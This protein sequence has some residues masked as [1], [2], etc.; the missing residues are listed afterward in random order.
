MGTFSDNFSE[1]EKGILRS[2]FS[3]SDSD[4]FAITTPSQVDRGSLMARYSRTDKSMRRVFLDEFLTNPNRGPEFYRRVLLEYGDD[5]VAELGDAQIAIENVSQITVKKIEDSRI[6][7]S[8]LEKSTR[9]VPFNKKIN[10]MYRYLRDEDLMQSRYAD[11]YLETSDLM[12]D[13]YSSLIEP[14]MKYIKEVKPITSEDLFLDKR[15][16]SGFRFSDLK[17]EADIKSVTKAY[18]AAAR[19]KSLDTIRGLLT[20]GTLTN[21]AI[22][23]NGRAFEYLISKLRTS[24]MTETVKV[25][26]GIFQELKTVIPEFVDRSGGKY[27]D[28]L[29]DYISGTKNIVRKHVNE[30]FSQGPVGHNSCRVKLVDYDQ[31]DVAEK[32]VVAGILF[33][34]STHSYEQVAEL[35]DGM[36]AEKRAEVIRDYVKMRKNRRQR[37]GRAFENTEYNFSVVSNFGGFRDLHR[38]RILTMARQD[39]STD[40]G[41]DIPKEVIEAGLEKNF[42]DAMS[43][44]RDAYQTIKKDYPEQAQLVVALQYNYPYQAKMNLREAT[45]MI[46]L[47]STPQGHPDYRLIVQ[48]MYSWIKNVHPVLSE[49]IKFVDNEYYFLNRILAQ[50]NLEKKLNSI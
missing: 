13:T 26:N 38:H 48:D 30:L 6:G 8:Y 19:A 10:G 29:Q 47:R 25:A 37:P 39:L 42:R 27:G 11:L 20:G 3:N 15:T 49:G 50:V 32:K 44:S 41:Y 43:A 35:V 7:L 16:Q 5:S 45:H 4:I 1:E 23:G 24:R 28:E 12:F 9:Y 40:Y 31:N 2:H 14:V 17:E 18:E 46:E 34:E 36:P 21:V 22:N 33:P